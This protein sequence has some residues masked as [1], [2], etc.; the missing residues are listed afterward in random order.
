MKTR[1]LILISMFASMIAIGAFIRIPAPMIGYFTLQLTFVILAGIVLGSKKGALAATVYAL[2]GLLGIPWFTQGG[3]IGYVLVP[4][5]GFIL[6]FILGAYIAG[7]F[8]EI[9]DS[10]LFITIGS[11]IATLVVWGLGYIYLWGIFEFYLGK[12]NDF[13]PF[14]LSIFSYSFVLDLILAFGVAVAGKRL[15]KVLR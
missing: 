7:K 12:S 5:F 14:M 11:I 8:R 6:A 1:D 9:N 13:I 4:T 3:G 15:I 2:G 10:L